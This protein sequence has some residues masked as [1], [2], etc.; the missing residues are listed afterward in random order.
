MK[1]KLLS[2][3][4]FVIGLTFIAAAQNWQPINLAEVYNYQFGFTFDGD[5]EIYTIKTDSV[6]VIANDSVFYLNRVALPCDTCSGDFQNAMLKNQP[7]FL[8]R[9]MIKSD[10]N[11]GVYAFSDTLE[12][13]IHALA[14]LN[15][16][17]D[18]MPSQGITAEVVELAQMEVL[19]TVDSIK[20]IMLSN[21]KL[22]ILSKN[23]GIVTFP[24][25]YADGAYDLIGMETSQQ[26]YIVPDFWD[27]Y[28]FQ[29][30]D[31]FQYTGSYSYP[32]EFG[33]A[34]WKK[35]ILDKQVQDNQITYLIR[36]VGY[37]TGEEPY[38]EEYEQT[39]VNHDSSLVNSYNSDLWLSN[40]TS[41][42]E[43][44][45]YQVIG[46][47][48]DANNEVSQKYT[49]DD[50]GALFYEA[51]L[52][53]P[54]ASED[55]LLLEWESHYELFYGVGLGMIRESLHF[56]EYSSSTTLIGYVKDGDTTGTVYS[57]SFL[58]PVEKHQAPNAHIKAWPNPA[59]ELLNVSWDASIS[60]SRVQLF[61]SK[62]TLAIEQPIDRNQNESSVD[63]STLHPG[64]YLIR[65]IAD[66]RQ[67]ESVRVV[68]Q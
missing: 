53:Y 54:E 36:E 32:Y 52:D 58:L 45:L 37:E 30:G 55:L 39:F 47:L 35:T 25:L 48:Y 3:I 4:L 34:D 20:R 31:V 50:Y 17:W 19:G 9:K 10:A 68:V 40:E 5:M 59:T 15:D 62:G 42:N 6:E 66:G 65:L 7:Q 26:G 63:L 14:E 60:A 64:I 61:D 46:Y 38:I 67:S 11:D 28:D 8:M 23:H 24:D 44:P 49:K 22:I 13:S 16:S 29:I 41:V 2:T 56:F 33:Y 43:Y 27:F 57:D 1:R 51:N 18:F 12:F 21:D